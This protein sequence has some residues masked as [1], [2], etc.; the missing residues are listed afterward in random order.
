MLSVPSKKLAR[1]SRG[2]PLVPRAAAPV[3]QPRRPD[4]RLDHAPPARIEAR[5][6]ELAR[7]GDKLANDAPQQNWAASLDNQEAA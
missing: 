6:S 3:R 7:A 1:Q 4:R 2:R 5:R